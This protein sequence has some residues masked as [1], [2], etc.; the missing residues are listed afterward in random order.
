[1]AVISEQHGHCVVE[2]YGEPH[3]LRTAARPGVPGQSPQVRQEPRDVERLV[4]HGIDPLGP[5]LP[6][7]RLHLVPVAGDQHDPRRRIRSPDPP[8]HH[9][10]VPA[11]EPS[12]EQDDPGRLA[13]PLDRLAFVVGDADPIAAFP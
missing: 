12:V 5:E 1:M 3:Y 8:E 4:M 9:A 2:E 6:D 7:Q 11:G 10:A 13:Q